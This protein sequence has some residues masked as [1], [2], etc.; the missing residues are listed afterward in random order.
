MV[1]ALNRTARPHAVFFAL[2][3]LPMTAAVSQVQNVGG[4]SEVFAGSDLERYLRYLQTLGLV[5][6]YPWTIR[7]FSPLETDSL[8]PRS[9]A[10]PWSARYDMAPHS[11]T[12]RV[13]ADI[14]RPT[15]SIRYNSAFPY[16]SNDGPVW[17][18]R[19][20]TEAFQ[21][22]LRTRWY[23]LSL[24]LAPIVFRAENTAFT[25]MP[26]GASGTLGFGD[27]QYPFRVDRPQRFGMRPY[28]VFD[29]GESAV[30]IDT[31]LIAAGISTAEQVWGPAD[32]YPFILSNNAAGFPHVFFGSGMP[33]N[34][35][36]G[37]LQ[38]RLVYGQLSQSDY[39][40]AGS[41]AEHR[42]MSGLILTFLPRPL[43]GLE[44]GASRFFHT[45]WPTGGPSWSDFRIPVEGFFKRTLNS[46]KSGDD[47]ANQLAS[48]YARWVLPHSGFEV[49]GEFGREDH[50]WD[51]RDFLLEP[52]QAAAHTFGFRKVWITSP[53]HMLALRSEV[54]DMRL[55]TLTRKR[56]IGGG[57]YL[58]ATLP[59]GHTERGQL[60]GA[61]V[62]AGS[63]AGAS[64][65]LE[66][67]DPTGRWAI[68][69]TRTL[70]D[71]L[72]TYYS[73]GIRPPKA[74]ETQHSIGAEAV[75]FWRSF[76]LRAVVTG[77]YDMNRYFTHDAFNLNAILGVRWG[78]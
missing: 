19:G 70:I 75:R 37:H 32:I 12:G 49:Y 39:S 31:R 26:N 6:S 61:D 56:D 20:L 59:Q 17:A 45:P 11:H 5:G 43:P 13:E 68:T 62:T 52:D 72:D 18:G 57:Y 38:S 22:G 42:F 34:L 46:A 47:N 74:P 14:V 60:L 44:L 33:W 30:R 2:A 21:G 1:F 63:G 4:R 77:V 67:Y 55:N 25:L 48:I 23:G 36:I 29:P 28:G 27:R 69:W 71:T 76:D 16:G 41:S 3:I 53:Q 64:V 51:F 7:D 24:T 65:A 15:A 73:T 9:S 58:N 78:W 10:H 35:W 54:I 8:V 66:S 50:S 40:S